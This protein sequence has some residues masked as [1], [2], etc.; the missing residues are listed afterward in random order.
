M[1][2]RWSMNSAAWPPTSVVNPGSSARMSC[3]RSWLVSSSSLPRDTT[4]M[5]ATSRDTRCGCCTAAVPGIRSMR[6]V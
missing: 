4:S 6:A 2:S 1:L 3:T 5:R